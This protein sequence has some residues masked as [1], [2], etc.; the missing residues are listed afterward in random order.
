M[1]LFLFRT[2]SDFTAI[3]IELDDA[4]IATQPKYDGLSTK[5]LRDIWDVHKTLNFAE[6]RFREYDANDLVADLNAVDAR[7]LKKDGPPPN[8]ATSLSLFAPWLIDDDLFAVMRYHFAVSLCVG[9]LKT[10][11]DTQIRIRSCV[12]P[13][14][15][16]SLYDDTKHFAPSVGDIAS[17][18]RR[19]GVTAFCCRDLQQRGLAVPDIVSRSR[20]QGRCARRVCDGF[21][22]DT[23]AMSATAQSQRRSPQQ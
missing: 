6:Y 12:I 4:F 9:D 11:C 16:T 22:R 14:T 17:F 5:V 20:R 18:L 15:V 1:F 7:L 19:K 21:R 13:R 10:L 2:F 3:D 23:A 8:S